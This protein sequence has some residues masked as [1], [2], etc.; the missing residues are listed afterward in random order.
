MH[1]KSCNYLF[2]AICHHFK[3]QWFGS[4]HLNDII[5]L[6]ST[7]LCLE[8]L[9]H[10]LQCCCHIECMSS[11]CCSTYTANIAYLQC[12]VYF[13]KSNMSRNSARCFH[14]SDFFASCPCCQ[15]T[16]CRS[17]CDLWQ[18]IAFLTCGVCSCFSRSANACNSSR[19]NGKKQL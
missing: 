15:C 5:M 14:L 8:H 12:L 2:V 1:C 4:N 9:A 13:S 7:F 18:A 6:S 10:E 19:H 3:Q 17:I 16:L 11:F